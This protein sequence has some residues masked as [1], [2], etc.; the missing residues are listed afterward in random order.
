MIVDG[1]YVRDNDDDF[2]F[3]V[4]DTRPKK[5]QSP[6]LS[7]EVHRAVC[8]VCGHVEYLRVMY[9]ECITGVRCSVSN[10]KKSHGVI[11]GLSKKLAR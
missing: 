2:E 5:A 1:I 9:G 10:G 6:E 7:Y 3:D 4:L 8:T 11:V